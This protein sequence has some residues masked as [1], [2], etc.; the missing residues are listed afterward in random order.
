MSAEEQQEWRQWRDSINPR[1]LRRDIYHQI[2]VL[3][4]L[5]GLAPGA[6]EDVRDSLTITI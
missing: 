3:F 1:Q 5:P 2:D 4:S 6:V